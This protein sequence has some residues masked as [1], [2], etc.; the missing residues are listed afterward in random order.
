M[1]QFKA[2]SILFQQASELY[3]LYGG[4][5]DEAAY[6]ENEYMA[7]FRGES[8]LEGAQ[9][10]I[11]F[12]RQCQDLPWCSDKLQR[13][14]ENLIKNGFSHIFVGLVKADHT[15][16]QERLYRY[17]SRE[18]QQEYVQPELCTELDDMQHRVV[19]P[20]ALTMEGKAPYRPYFKDSE[21]RSCNV[22]RYLQHLVGI[23]LAGGIA[24]VDFAWLLTQFK[25][26]QKQTKEN[27]FGRHEHD[28][29]NHQVHYLEDDASLP[30]RLRILEVLVSERGMKP[31]T[32]LEAIR[33][34]Q[35]GIVRWIISNSFVRLQDQAIKDSTLNSPQGRKLLILGGQKIPSTATSG[36]FL[37]HACVEF[38]ALQTLAWLVEDQQVSIDGIIGGF[39]LLH[40][41]A[42]F[43]RT[44]ILLWLCKRAGFGDLKA[45][46]STRRGFEKASAVHVAV[47]RG[48]IFMADFLL[49]NFDCSAIDGMGRTPDVIAA[50]SPHKYVREWG[51]VKAR[52][53]TLGKEIDKLVRH[54]SKKSYNAAKNHIEST[55]CLSRE[56]W[57]DAGIYTATDTLPNGKSYRST[58][59]QCLQGHDESFVLWLSRELTLVKS[60]EVWDH[61]QHL[62][63][64]NRLWGKH[65]ENI[66]Q[67][68]Y[69]FKELDLNEATAFAADDEELSNWLSYSWDDPPIFVDP[70][71]SNPIL[72]SSLLQ[73]EVASTFRRQAFTVAICLGLVDSS[74]SH[75]RTAFSKGSP[76]EA[77]RTLAAIFKGAVRRLATLFECDSELFF[78]DHALF[79]SDEDRFINVTSVLIDISHEE[80]H[81]IRASPPHRFCSNFDLS[82]LHIA[83]AIEGYSHLVRMCHRRG[84]EW[85]ASMEAETARIG[86]FLS[87]E[88]ILSFFTR[89]ESHHFKA[90]YQDRCHAA[91]LGAAGA[92]R[93]N[94]WG[95]LL[96]LCGHISDAC[97]ED[98]CEIE[99]EDFEKTQSRRK[100]AADSSLAACIVFGYLS[101][102][103]H[104]QDSHFVYEAMMKRLIKSNGYSALSFLR[105][106]SLLF[107]THY[108][109]PPL[110]VFEG[111][112]HFL[113][114]GLNLEPWSTETMQY[115]KNIF[116][117]LSFLI[118]K[119]GD[120]E[121]VISWV[122]TLEGWGVDI[123]DIDKSE[124]MRL[125]DKL[126]LSAISLLKK[127]QLENWA[128]LD[129][130]KRGS[131]LVDI[132]TAIET[133]SLGVKTRDR[134]GLYV[135]HLSAAYNRVDVLQWL[136]E[137]QH[138]SLD[139]LDHQKRT[140]LDVAIASRAD[141][142]ITWIQNRNA[143]AK[144][145]AF[146]GKYF[147]KAL[148]L[149][150]KKRL[151]DGTSR[152]Q[153]IHRGRATRKKFQ[154]LLVMRMEESR[155]YNT[156]WAGTHAILHK[157]D[158]KLPS[159]SSLRNL[160]E[161]RL[162]EVDDLDDLIETGQRLEAAASKAATVEDEESGD[163]TTFEADNV[164]NELLRDTQ[165]NESSTQQTRSS[166]A[167]PAGRTKIHLSADT[168]KWLRQSDG[169]YREFFV[170]RV[171]Q[172]SAG[173]R[174]RILEKRLKGSASTIYETYLEQKS[175]HRILWQY[176]STGSILIWYVAKHKNVSRLMRLIDDSQSRSARQRIS[177]SALPE[178]AGAN[179][180]GNKNQSHNILLNPKGNVPLKLYK[181]KSSDL[182]Q[183]IDQ[184]WSP[185][186]Y[187]T[188]EERSIVEEVGTVL[189]LGRSGTGKTVC[190]CNR[191][192]LDRQLNQHNTAF[193]QLF[194]A[195]SQR[196][197]NYVKE[198]VGEY[199]GCTFS[200]FARL[201]EF[202]ENQLPKRDSVRHLFLPSQH[203]NYGRF[204]RDVH[205]GLRESVDPMVAWTNIRT[206]L[207]G[208]I[209][210][211]LEQEQAMTKEA[212]L[213]LGKKRCRLV[214]AEREDVYELFVRYRKVMAGQKLWDSCDRIAALL[215]RMH[216]AQEA[217]HVSY[218]T[219]RRAKIY[220]DEIQ[221]YTQGEI[222]LF[223]Q[224]S[225]PG[226]LFLAGDPA[227]SVVEGVEFRFEE[228]RS[229]GYHVAGPER[230]DLIPQK[231]K[232]V[233]VN[234]R[235]HSGVLDTA[236]A[237]LQRMFDSFPDSAKQLAKDRG[238]FTG[239]RPGVF[240]HV[241]PERLKQL[242]LEKLNGV[243]LLTHDS[244][245]SYW[246]EKLG[247]YQL[248]YGI[249]AAKGLE[250]KKVII[251]DF[252]GELPREIQKPWRDLLLGR[253]VDKPELEG[254]LKLLYTA[255]TR[256]IEQLFFAETSRSIA[257]DAFVRWMTTKSVRSTALA[258]KQNVDDV[259]A[260]V[261]TQDEWI[262]NGL[263]SAELAEANEM[264][265]DESISFVEKALFCFQQGKEVALAQKARTHRISLLFQQ[266]L[267]Q[268]EVNKEDA[269][270]E[271]R[272]AEI[273]EQLL[274][275][276]LLQEA[277]RLMESTILPRLGTFSREKLKKEFLSLLDTGSFEG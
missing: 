105:A 80:S 115:V 96:E 266:G 129:L 226:Q 147:R 122:R 187:L 14:L 64:L 271:I 123:Q 114:S 98:E 4:S 184:D 142:A 76:S 219:V 6:L 230:Q 82:R 139:E 213:A 244:S 261:M 267:Q 229:V 92:A 72:W 59:L 164:R 170:R 74:E 34:R 195:R 110:V 18:T 177:A 77:I 150:R 137:T 117:S 256:C 40:A 191:M 108:I 35:C 102:K 258:T 91:L 107:E 154:G 160:N 146:L 212:F 268:G 97:L 222:L 45:A 148:A 272:S 16:L 100:A 275:E 269:R 227:Q 11:R 53:F 5:G 104:P 138:A 215:K 238:L 199:E 263:E 262:A 233:T 214:A 221:D 265:L 63:G 245:V 223:F 178:L 128:K 159:W 39:N 73:G 30:G 13:A 52:P 241:Q 24:S 157:I 189:L 228:I 103:Q 69:M 132:K 179:E 203:M 209:E 58:I 8:A 113:Y 240:S 21:E 111:F 207:K 172:L 193:T 78:R 119:E 84:S 236:A 224:L 210:A 201:V 28:I 162:A 93:Q 255:V 19:D 42:F 135:S 23:H 47:N 171:Q 260:M 99:G 167:A 185:Q 276:N 67:Y 204:K 88:D 190:I 10:L 264:D 70:E 274:S 277:H 22:R 90:P 188:D 127:K 169:K 197:W 26:A 31:P 173:D 250:F 3:Y 134:G 25:G 1:D 183:I 60:A 174:S 46:L 124:R 81:P 130:I 121:L 259:E 243:V 54:I 61:K 205:R 140:V 94:E 56:S 37:A 211:L 57:K 29:W 48:H 101:V 79:T 86:A 202:L 175:G 200:T 234:F 186:L 242:V 87:H 216:A 55:K 231:P 273:L 89:T 36:T 106:A 38:D 206:F 149:R 220:V 120:E 158:P 43:G 196:L 9:R 85:T 66:F 181:I 208:S 144:I 116:G 145:S 49:G 125:R 180:H 239:P 2:N 253:A 32:V 68:S 168:I 270:F 83:L 33:V 112:V 166:V 62:D 235:S 133:N 163:D 51:K 12:I 257:G 218:D 194:V 152:L 161:N 248:V 254:Q 95:R 7:S 249:R 44:E 136:V 247:G 246:K 232:T 176:E 153:A 217:G 71:D 198:T 75:A 109:R 15:I 192:D 182:E 225:G 165:S 65:G 41:C 237:V 252:F 155:R 143:K 156:I 131:S 141:S 151:V 20:M 50:S 27:R 126:V 17:G 251:L 118:D